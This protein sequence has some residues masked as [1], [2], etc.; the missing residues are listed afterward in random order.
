MSTVVEQ[1]S[2]L[3]LND[4]RH[5]MYLHRTLSFVQAAEIAGVSQSALSQS[6]SRMEKRLGVMLFNRSR[7]AV[8]ATAFADLIAERAE[9]ILNLLED[10]DSRIDALRHSREGGVRFGVG[11]IP[12]ALILGEAMATFHRHHSNTQIRTIVD[13]P[14]ELAALAAARE[15]EFLVA[16]DLPQWRDSETVRERLLHYRH[17]L[18]CRPG[19]PLTELG[20]VGFRDCIRYPVVSFPNRFLR[21]KMLELIETSDEFALLQRNFPTVQMQH[22]DMMAE[23]VATSDFVMFSP[24]SLLP[25]QIESGRLVVREISDL[26]LDVNVDVIWQKGF[27]LSP[28]S[29]AMIEILRDVAS[30][31]DQA[32]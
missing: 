7:R 17:V 25:T 13:Y 21:S 9:S 28:A 32:Q 22:P 8:S 20:S 1:V 6:I 2:K 26:Q 14:D 15:V 30:R 11:V 29:E 31:L 23:L 10:M 4:L 12:A 5:V 16:A 24:A 3:S 19:H 27:S 18:V